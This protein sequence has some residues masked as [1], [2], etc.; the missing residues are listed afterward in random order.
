MYYYAEN[1]FYSMVQKKL[2][3]ISTNNLNNIIDLQNIK[4]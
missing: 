2:N 1:I 3:Y 4:N